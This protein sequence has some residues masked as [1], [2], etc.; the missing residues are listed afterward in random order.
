MTGGSLIRSA[1]TTTHISTA[2][3]D[4]TPA[5]AGSG[6]GS[7]E[8]MWDGL[9]NPA[10]A[11]YSGWTRLAGGALV[12]ADDPSLHV[13]DIVT[14][15]SVRI[16]V[17]GG[18]GTCAAI[19]PSGDAV[20]VATLD[21][22]IWL[23][24]ADADGSRVILPSVPDQATALAISPS[25][26]EVLTAYSQLVRLCDLDRRV[27]RAEFTLILQDGFPPTAAMFSPDGERAVLWSSTSLW[28]CDIRSGS[29]L[30][31][32]PL[33]PIPAHENMDEK[34]LTVPF[35]FIDGG[36]RL[37]AADGGAI[38]TIDVRTGQALSSVPPR[39]MPL[40]RNDS[41]TLVMRKGAGNILAALPKF[42]R[43]GAVMPDGQ[44]VVLNHAGWGRLEIL[45]LEGV[46]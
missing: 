22:I 4:A 38:L 42:S 34:R 32:H 17:E 18:D 5:S 23:S 46:E 35:V 14:G 31:C 21:G 26:R 33:R 12:A 37:H 30:A 9:N 29:P 27:C 19:A 24:L 41:G 20:A 28:I 11:A 40:L 7:R 1:G 44:T 43:A 15:E 13:I 45:K 39:P 10:G 2:A 8:I 36:Q 16:K 25:G 6:T 3:I